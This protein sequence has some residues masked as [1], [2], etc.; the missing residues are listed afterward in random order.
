MQLNAR[1]GRALDCGVK[2]PGVTDTHE[3]NF[4][5]QLSFVREYR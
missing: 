1:T 2:S 5:F 4:L 3:I